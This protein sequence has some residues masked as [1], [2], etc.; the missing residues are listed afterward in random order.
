MARINLW[1]NDTAHLPGRSVSYTSR[2]AYMRAGSR[3]TLLI[4]NGAFR[5]RKCITCHFLARYRQVPGEVFM[6]LGH[7]RSIMLRN[8]RERFGGLKGVVGA[9][10]KVNRDGILNSLKRG[11]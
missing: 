9:G 7:V 11:T 1:H 3:L 10:P 2:E 6:V 5:Y 8:G 4:V